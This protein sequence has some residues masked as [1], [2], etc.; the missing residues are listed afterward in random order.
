MD[1]PDGWMR[2]NTRDYFL[3]TRDGVDLQYIMVE[4]IN[5]KDTL[6]HTK[7]KFRKGMLPSEA[8]EVILDN[9]ASSGT[10]TALRSRIT[11]RRKLTANPGSVR[12]LPIRPAMG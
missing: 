3:I 1:L 5:V 10:C 2:W 8:A 4:K 7:K 11:S 12:F 9:I 6:K